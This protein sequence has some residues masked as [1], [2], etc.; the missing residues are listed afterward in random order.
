MARIFGI[1]IALLFSMLGKT[2][3]ALFRNE[4]LNRA[5]G[6]LD[7]ALAFLGIAS[8]QYNLG[9]AYRNGEGVEQDFVEA[10]K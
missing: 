4:L 2:A 1:L 10:V 9:Y 6:I 3:P 7:R 5:Q 8:A